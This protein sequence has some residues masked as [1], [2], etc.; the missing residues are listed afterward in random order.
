MRSFLQEIW[1]QL[2]ADTQLIVEDTKVLLSTNYY[3]FNPVKIDGPLVDINLGINING[4]GDDSH[5]TFVLKQKC[6]GW[7]CK[8]ALKPYD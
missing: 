6:T 8:T 3:N 5:E 2:I 1:P 4:D 7:I